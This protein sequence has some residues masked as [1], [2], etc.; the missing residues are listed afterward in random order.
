MVNANARGM[1]FAGAVLLSAAAT[2]GADKF[3][4]AGWE[5]AGVGVDELLKRADEYDKTPLDGCIVYLEAKGVDGVH[6]TSRNIIHQRA[7][8]DEDFAPLVPRYRELLKHRAFRHSF[9]NSYRAPTNRVAWTDDAMWAKIANQM[10]VEAKFAKACGFDGL[11]MDPEDYHRQRQYERSDA[12]GL[13]YARLA[14][15]ARARGAEVFRGVFHEFPDVKLLS[16]W[17]LST[18]KAFRSRVSAQHIRS[19]MERDE[20]DLWPHFVDGIFDVLPNT[21]TVIDGCEDGYTWMAPRLQFLEAT[22]RM[23]EDFAGLLSPENRDKYRARTQF[24]FGV[25]L[26]GYSVRTNGFWYMPPTDGSRF[27][28]L[29]ANLRQASFCA[30]E[31]IWFWGERRGWIGE[32]SWERELPG[33]HSLVWSV[34][35]DRAEL[36]RVLRRRMERGE[37][38]PINANGECKGTDPGKV[39]PPYETW[40]QE[41]KYCPQ[42]GTF[43]C[44]LASGDGDSSSLVARNVGEGCFIVG[45]NGYKPGDTFGLSFSSKGR[46]VAATVGWRVNGKWDWSIPGE[47]VP[48][49]GEPS[50]DA[51]TR[52]DWGF[53][54]PEGANGF[55]LML[56]VRQDKGETCWFDNVAIIPAAP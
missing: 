54:I 32:K 35:G 5:F 17:L 40:Q 7:W 30:S 41:P 45:A 3:I 6:L 27:K 34:K 20:K 36:G 4:A 56:K 53:A 18:T 38:S 25:Y 24:S 2:A 1:L 12:D 51:W 46:H 16:Y 22:V 29:A 21:A 42:Q 52:T 9:L 48:I 37:L 10:R 13:P 44:D 28:T 31:Y 11:Q 14:A 8:T 26:D 47:I 39:P 50:A 49:Q 23:R 33:L 43:G 15:L 19:W 55:G